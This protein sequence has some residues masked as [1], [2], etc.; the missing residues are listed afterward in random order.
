M[1]RYIKIILAVGIFICMF[2]PLSK[3]TSDLSGPRKQSENLK[4]N[5]PSAAPNTHIIPDRITR[6]ADQVP[7]SFME[8]VVTISFIFPLLLC[9]PFSKNR[10]LHLAHLVLQILFSIWL[11]L[12]VYI[13]VYSFYTPLYGGYLLTLLAGAFFI[14]G[15][16]ELFTYIRHGRNS[17][18]HHAELVG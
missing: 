8:Y 7:T 15:L 17:V 11:L 9:I 5:N 4:I 2:L 3:C 6:I 14:Y 10:K 18:K 16:F 12:Q 13:L 1:P